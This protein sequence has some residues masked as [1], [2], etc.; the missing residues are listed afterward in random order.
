[1]ALAKRFYTVKNI[2]YI[3]KVSSLINDTMKINEKSTKDIYKGLK[4][5]LDIC[6][7]YHLYQLYCNLAIRVNS[8][9]FLDMVKNY[10]NNDETLNIISQ[11][12]TNLNKKI[13]KKKNVSIT[14]NNYYLKL[15][16]LFYDLN[17]Q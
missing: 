2:T 10:I 12:L 6:E 5:S 9:W 7:K 15:N 1:M 11:I 16:K 13:F 3:F 14:I 8:D 4:E 17:Y